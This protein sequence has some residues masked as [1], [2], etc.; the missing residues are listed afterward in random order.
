MRQSFIVIGGGIG[1]L[2]AALGLARAGR[3]VRVLERAQDFS[4]IGAGLQLGPNASRV[5]DDLGVLPAVHETA[6]FPSRLTMCDILDGRQIATLDLGRGF[7]ERY[8]YPYVV[9]HRTDLQQALLAACRKV[10]LIDLENDCEVIALD[11]DGQAQRVRCADGRS[12]SA[13]GIV[14]ADG[15][16]SMVRA[17]LIA[18]G[19]PVDSRYVAYRGTVAMSELSE[20]AG[21]DNVVLFTGHEFHLV[22]YPV[23]KSELYN[24]VAVFKIREDA[25]D[26]DQSAISAELDHRFAKACVQ[27][28]RALPTVGRARRWRLYD[29]APRPGWSRG[30]IT[31]LGDAAHPMLQYLAQGACQALE[32][33]VSLARQ[34]QLYDGDIAAAF[35][36]Y[37]AIRS[38]RTARV[39]DNARMFGDIIHADST[40]RLLRDALLARTPSDDFRYVEW[41][42]GAASCTT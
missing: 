22:Q 6:V 24:Q 27:V 38:P 19:K 26:S 16:H 1:G 39:Q 33:A 2:A 42:Y 28:R 5:L 8:G 32:D 25:D 20:H 31:L 10:P 9:M 15:L 34:V 41:L 17:L 12:F 11:R 35:A 30:C 36:A 29:R 13:D 14:G 7:Q 18:D 23:R 40:G 3:A 37:E 4:E 21:L